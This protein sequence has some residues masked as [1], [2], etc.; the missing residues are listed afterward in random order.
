MY[1]YAI[2]FRIGTDH[3]RTGN[4]VIFADGDYNAKAIAEAQFGVGQVLSYSR[5]YE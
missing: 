5:I 1:K 4:A 3:Q 2:W